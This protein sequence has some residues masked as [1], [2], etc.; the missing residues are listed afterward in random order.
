MGTLVV[1]LNARL[2]STQKFASPQAEQLFLQEFEPVFTLTA[3]PQDA[4]PN[5]LMYRAFPNDWVLARKPKVGKPVSIAS[6]PN[7]LTDD[8]CRQAYESIEVSD[9]EKGIENVVDK[10]AGWLQ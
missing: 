6:S 2:R 10:L 8:E 4:A 1:L 7:R 9:M 3:A 5:C